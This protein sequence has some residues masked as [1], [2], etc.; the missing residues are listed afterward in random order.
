MKRIG[1]LLIAAA[2]LLSCKSRLT[3]AQLQ[4]RTN[5]LNQLAQ[6]INE[7]GFEILIKT[8]YPL[9]TAALN[10][11]SNGILLQ[12]GN[13]ANRIDLSGRND[14][15]KRKGNQVMADLSYY[16]ERQLTAGYLEDDG[17]INF[18]D[19][20]VDYV[21]EVDSE[22]GV[23]RIRFTARDQRNEIYPVQLAI[24]ES[25]NTDVNITSSHRTNIRYT[26]TLKLLEPTTE[27]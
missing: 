7:N 11:V 8:A 22:K 13:S 2:V 21:Q 14:F 12:T 15:I 4:D 27:L 18:K 6:D 3:T 16:G 19:T 23:L 20:A 25:M 9:N 26:G 5:K 10:S 1:L 17:G 24:D